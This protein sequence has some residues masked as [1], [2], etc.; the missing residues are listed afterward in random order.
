MRWI[1]VKM[2]ELGVTTHP[3]YKISLF[4]DHQSMV[5]LVLRLCDC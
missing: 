3:N 1:E 4:M 5:R 2:R